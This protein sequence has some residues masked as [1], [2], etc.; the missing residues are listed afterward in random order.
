MVALDLSQ[1]HCQALLI[2]CLRFIKKHANHAKK[3]K[4]LNQNVILFVLKIID[5][6]YRPINGLI[7]KFPNTYRFC[8]GYVNKF[9]LLLRKGAYP[10]EYMDSWKKFNET[11][12]PDKET[13]YSELNKEGITYEDY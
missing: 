13:F 2:T 8:N 9:V 1:L 12:K 3:E 10:Y 4:K 5:K 7:K 11:S 6:S